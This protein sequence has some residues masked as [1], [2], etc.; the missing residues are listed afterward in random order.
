MLTKINITN[1]IFKQGIMTAHE[2]M[3]ME[4]EKIDTPDL[5][6]IPTR[7]RRVM[8]PS[9]WY[10]LV[11]DVINLAK[12]DNMFPAT[13]KVQTSAVIKSMQSQNLQ[14]GKIMEW[15]Y[16]FIAMVQSRPKLEVRGLVSM[17]DLFNL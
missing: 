1:R 8:I 2:A 17:Y 13:I 6:L 14:M 3:Q 4:L 11:Q 5:E 12:Q 9:T 16:L 15:K 10:K 7:L